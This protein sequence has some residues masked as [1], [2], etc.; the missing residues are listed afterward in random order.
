MHPAGLTPHLRE[1]PAVAPKDELT[2]GEL[3]GQRLPGVV[4]CC[5]DGYWHDVQL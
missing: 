4:P 2:L 1:L 5:V 3:E